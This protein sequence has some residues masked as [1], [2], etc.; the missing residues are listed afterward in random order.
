MKYTIF[1]LLFIAANISVSTAQDSKIQIV[2]NPDIFVDEEDVDVAWIRVAEA[3]ISR[4]VST[5]FREVVKEC[6][7]VTERSLIIEQTA[8]YYFDQISE[9]LPTEENN[10]GFSKSRFADEKGVDLVLL[11]YIDF[12]TRTDENSLTL[13]MVLADKERVLKTSEDEFLKLSL[14]NPATRKESAKINDELEKIMRKLLDFK[15]LKENYP[16]YRNLSRKCTCSRTKLQRFLLRNPTVTVGSFAGGVAL[17]TYGLLTIGKANQQQK[18]FQE[19][20]YLLDPFYVEKRTNR[21]DFLKDTRVKNR[22]GYTALSA[23]A[24]LTVVGGI[25]LNIHFG[26]DDTRNVYLLGKQKHKYEEWDSEKK[27]A[28]KTLRISPLIDYNPVT[29]QINSQIKFTYQF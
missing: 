27:Y 11:T 25:G 24:L 14:F 22:I 16:R 28:R 29:T 13:K 15:Y 26:S 5:V 19:H 7:D 6:Q 12:T 23:G 4:K 9:G 3:N 18:D 2:V 10:L 8:Q 21:D 17:S 20:T 1:I